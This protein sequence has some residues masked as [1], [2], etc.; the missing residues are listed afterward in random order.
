MAILTVIRGGGDLAS[1][2]ALRL[3]RIG[4]DTIITELSEPLVVRRTVSFAEAVFGGRTQVEEVPGCLALDYDHA[5]EILHEG[6]IPVIV[7][8][9]LNMLDEIRRRQSPESPLV[10]IDARMTKKPP[11]FGISAA[12]LVIG[13]GPGF[14]AGE[15]CHAVIETN[16]GHNMGR[17]FW[18]GTA[19]MDT[20]MPEKVNV[21]GVDRVLRAPLDGRFI[22]FLEIGEHVD[23]GQIIG[24][25]SK[26]PIKAPF[27]GVLRGILHSG[28]GVRRG[29]KIGDVDPRDDP[30]YCF[31]VSDKSLAIGGGVTEA[32]LSS[33][34]FRYN[35]WD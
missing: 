13:L 6:C 22:A 20:G 32:I 29:L 34:E 1:G 17:V 3:F 30:R 24:E 10:L 33:K 23:E 11:D 14:I 25:V 18:Q 5:G 28:I 8:P 7:D 2:V 16:R 35:L 27:K 21:H 15:N 19:E 4:I 9:G 31:L 26:V 12:D